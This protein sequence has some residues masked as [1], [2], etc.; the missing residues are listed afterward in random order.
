MWTI[1]DGIINVVRGV[2]CRI[3][4]T[5]FLENTKFMLTFVSIFIFALSPS[6]LTPSTPDSPSS[7]RL[8][9]N[10]YGP[11]PVGRWKWRRSHESEKGGGYCYLDW[12]RGSVVGV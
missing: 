5:P 3:A 7:V 10:R 8:R 11:D 1:D 2:E 9:G 6:P 4:Y 12:D